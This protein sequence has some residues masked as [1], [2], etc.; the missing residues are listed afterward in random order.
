MKDFFA[1][2]FTNWKTTLAGILTLAG[3]VFTCINNGGQLLDC[4]IDSWPIVF[5]GGGLLFARDAGK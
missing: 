4:V 1:K 5:A 2:L 3:L